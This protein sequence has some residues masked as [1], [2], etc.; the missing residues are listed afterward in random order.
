MLE[1]SRQLAA[2]LPEAVA[3]LV[4][5]PVETGA[6]ESLAARLDTWLSLPEAE[7]ETA[8]RAL[9]ETVARLW[10]WDA[11]ARGVLGA[12]RGELGDLPLPE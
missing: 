3:P 12:A 9:V 4:S 10:S 6:V 7:R 5:F 8:R 1:V 2:S 11:V